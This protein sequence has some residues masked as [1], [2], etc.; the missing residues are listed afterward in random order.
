MRHAFAVLLGGLIVAAAVT[1]A[2]AQRSRPVPASR[3]Q[4]QAAPTG[5]TPPVDKK[6]LDR[7]DKTDRKLLDELIGFAPPKFTE[8]LVWVRPGAGADPMRWLDL[9]GK[10][11]LVQSWTSKS[12]SGR[13][14]PA[15]VERTVGELAGDDLVVIL[16]HT[17][18]GAD[19][20]Q[21]FLEKRPPK[22]P[23]V[24]DGKGTYCDA[25]GVYRRPVNILVDRQGVV[26]YVGLNNRG[27]PAALKKLLD[28]PFDPDV[29]APERPEAETAEKTT[30]PEIVGTM[31][32]AD[33]VRGRPGPDLYV[34]RWMNGA[35]ARAPVVVVM[36][37]ETD[38]P[39][40][41]PHLKRFSEL[42]HGHGGAV[43]VVA[44]SNENKMD[45]ED[46]IDHIKDETGVRVEQLGVSLGI[47]KDDR[48][49]RAIGVR[50]V[51]HALVLDRTWTVRW[52]GHAS[53]VTRPILERI[54]KADRE[55]AGEGSASDPRKRWASGKKSRRR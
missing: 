6:W 7:L 45:F 12:G 41:V 42:A 36:F 21:P 23:V 27:T 46:G 4:D 38:V 2:D 3:Q 50:R 49:R 25:L 47:D 15:R 53:S 55:T 31:A 30:F 34:K 35:P 20:V 11:V 10:V 33:D 54:V 51:P 14:V 16:L 13:K 24:I 43:A 32:D 8:N 19:R 22:S 48:M 26:R 39:A 18:D 29:N 52:Q 5:A 44:I 28:E 17:P 9:R 37:W 1:P 40:C